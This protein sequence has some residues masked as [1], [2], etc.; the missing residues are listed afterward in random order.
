[1]KTE[2]S[3]VAPNVEGLAGFES[4]G[5]GIISGVLSASECVNLRDELSS[6]FEA[7]QTYRKSKQGGVRNLLGRSS[8]VQTL[9]RSE[10]I[11]GIVKDALRG[12]AFPVRA[13]FFDKLPS[14]NWLVPL[15]QDL[16]IAVKERK[17]VP[18]FSGW[19]IKD[20]V[21]HVQPP[22]DVLE[23]MV[24]VRLHL[25]DCRAENGALHVWPKSHLHGK[26]TAD[27]IREWSDQPHLVCEVDQGGALL[28]RPLLL[29]ASFPSRSPSHR[30]VI[31]IE[32]TSDGLPGGLEWSDH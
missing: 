25:D 8:S 4:D 32:Y 12:D 3:S 7:D 22:A 9:A 31:H 24:T 28:M 30:R 11:L 26:L 6:L 1:M 20:G 13:I 17:E 16:S 19:S 10:K 23:K 21:Q 29:H 27:Q 5:F 18:G 2:R 14:A 15:H